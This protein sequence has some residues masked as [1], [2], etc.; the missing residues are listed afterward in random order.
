LTS[1]VPAGG[2][3]KGSGFAYGYLLLGNWHEILLFNDHFHRGRYFYIFGHF[4]ILQTNAWN[5][6]VSDFPNGISISF[7]DCQF[8]AASQ[9]DIQHEGRICS[10][11][12]RTRVRHVQVAFQWKCIV[13]FGWGFQ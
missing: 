8:L 4:Y 7:R 11:G 5:S 6:F 1:S 2:H 9:I 12:I 13:V 10:D 3:C